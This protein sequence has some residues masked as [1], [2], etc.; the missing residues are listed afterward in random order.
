MRNHG[1]V[2]ELGIDVCGDRARAHRSTVFKLEAASAAVLDQ[3][4]ADRRT[5]LDL[6]AVTGCRARH[7]LSDCAHP[8][9]ACPHTRFFP[10]TSPNA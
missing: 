10:F 4:A 3:N 6:H 7:R 5:G 8:P 1:R 2:Q 9:I